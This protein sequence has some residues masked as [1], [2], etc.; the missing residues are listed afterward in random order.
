MEKWLPDVSIFAGI[1]LLTAGVYFIY[2]PLAF[3]IPGIFL[4]YLGWPKKGVK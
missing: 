1:S 3:I 4:V 2:M